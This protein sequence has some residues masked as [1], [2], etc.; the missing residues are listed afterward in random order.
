MNSKRSLKY[1]IVSILMIFTMIPISAYSLYTFK[2]KV[3]DYKKEFEKSVY[4]DLNSI[5]LIMDN[6]DLNNKNILKTFLNHPYII[7]I[8]E[9]ELNKEEVIRVINEY[10]SIYEQVASLALG[11][12][13]GEMYS[14]SVSKLPK[15]YDPRVRPWYVDTANTSMEVVI[16]PI[17]KSA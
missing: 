11:T 12:A 10:E 15:N 2:N 16:S 8:K 6:T 7:K 14:N 13:D 4:N 9:Q 3:S 5:S 17:Y 1:I